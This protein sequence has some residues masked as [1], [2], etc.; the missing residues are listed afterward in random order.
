MKLLIVEDSKLE[1]KYL[2]DYFN[3]HDSFEILEAQNG[4]EALNI[5]EKEKNIDLIILDWIMPELDGW[6]VCKKIRRLERENGNYSYIIMLTA[7]TSKEDIIKG[8]EIGVDDY[9]T[10]PFDEDELAVRV[11]VGKR[12]LNMYNKIK[13]LNKKLEFEAT[14]DELTKI[15]NRRKIYEILEKSISINDNEVFLSVVDVD[16]FKKVNDKYGHQAGDFILIKMTKIISKLINTYGYF[17]RIGGE[18]FL[19][20]FINFKKKKGLD[21]MDIIRKTIETTTF[22]FKDNNIKITISIGSTLYKTGESIDNLISRADNN[23]YK[24]K[25]LGRNNVIFE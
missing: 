5:Y 6:D 20:F 2:I 23:L 24:A 17:G 22:K 7:K 15:Y 3:K 14:H 25:E 21:L 4:L 13:E 11:S 9:I 12:I 18:E 1:R 8:F 16:H 19:M 10:K